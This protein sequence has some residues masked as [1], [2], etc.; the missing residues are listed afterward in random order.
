[1]TRKVLFWIRAVS[2]DLGQGFAN[3]S[4]LLNFMEMEKNYHESV[5]KFSGAEE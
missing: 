2:L 3:F 4:H 1:M 5:I